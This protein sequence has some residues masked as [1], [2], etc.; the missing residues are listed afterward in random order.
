MQSI[1]EIG[2]SL[3]KVFLGELFIVVVGVCNEI[4]LVGVFFVVIPEIYK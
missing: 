1:A 3:I 2:G 4:R